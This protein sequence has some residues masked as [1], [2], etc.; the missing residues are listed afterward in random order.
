MSITKK[1]LINNRTA[2]KKAVI[3]RSNA[4]STAVN[5][6]PTV[7]APYKIAALKVASMKVAALKVAALKVAARKR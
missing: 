5:A 4:G 2:A 1:S 6:G 7:A 3:A